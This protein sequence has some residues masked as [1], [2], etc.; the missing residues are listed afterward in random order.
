MNN[1]VVQL[2]LRTGTFSTD[3]KTARGQVQNFQQGCQTAGKSISNFGSA[4]GLNVGTLSKFAG[5]AGAAYLAGKEFKAIMDSTQTTSDAFQNAIAGCQGVIDSFNRAIAMSDFSAFSNG[6]WDVY[7]AAKAARQAMDDLQD[8]YSFYGLLSSENR[9][10]FMTAQE[11]FRNPSSTPAQKEQYLKDAQSAIDESWED[12]AGLQL[13][14]IDNFQK[15]VQS[16]AGK[17]NVE[18]QDINFDQLRTVAKEFLRDA[19]A[20]TQKY[21]SGYNKMLSERNE[22]KVP[23]SQKSNKLP[24]APDEYNN[25]SEVRNIVRRHKNDV[26]GY[27]ILQ[28]K[29]EDRNALINTVVSLDNAKQ[30]II[31]EEKALDKMKKGDTTPV[32]T[33]KGGSTNTN[34]VEYQEGQLGYYKQKKNEAIGKYEFAKTYEEYESITKEVEQWQ[35]EID[36]I[37][38]KQGGENQ[39]LDTQRA[40]YEDIIKKQAEIKVTADKNSEAYKNAVNEIG[41]AKRALLGFDLT[42]ALLVDPPTLQSLK[43]V[44]NILV[45][46]RE[47]SLDKS[48]YDKWTKQ[49]NEYS[50]KIEA[51]EGKK[52]TSIAPETDSWDKF[53]QAMANTS[54]IVSSLTNTF[55]ENSEVT[56]ASVLQMV[57]TCLP[58]IGSLIS[59]ISALTTV[60]AVEAGVGAVGKAVSTSKHWI[61]AIAAVAS[62]GAVVASAISAA[63]KPNI[64]RF[65]NG[66]IVGGSSF[67]GDR[68][69]A[70]VNSGEMILNKTQQARLFKIANGGGTE[71]NNVTFHISGTDLVGVLNNNNRKSKLIR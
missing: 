60:E 35:A 37:T 50:E 12:L 33:P 64:Q 36:K 40:Y 69:S 5:A 66:G 31:G 27:A 17:A 4:L 67:T 42:D 54:T 19:D 47:S 6:L 52:I 23:W 44:R 16:W 13:R 22:Y 53:N 21:T 20:A 58:A 41:K 30:V 15:K 2:L 14:T 48:E 61:E 70:Q 39:L 28:M 32:K 43:E 63:S 26:V 8:A 57:A 51:I 7:D 62:L 18:L 68:V 55:K 56:M 59:A 49:I 34:K 9:T 65:A 11:G 38:T 46:I 45:Q 29:D 10:K 71:G 25:L 1:L 3:L 24:G